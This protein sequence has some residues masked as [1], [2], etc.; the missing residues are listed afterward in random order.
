MGVAS[1][2]FD[3]MKRLYSNPLI[4][5]LPIICLF[6]YCHNSIKKEESKKLPKN[7]IGIPRVISNYRIT[8]LTDDT[9]ISR[10]MHIQDSLNTVFLDSIFN[11]LINQFFQELLKEPTSEQI[12]ELFQERVNDINF[13]NKNGSWERANEW[14]DM[15][16]STMQHSG[17]NGLSLFKKYE[18][19]LARLKN[20]ILIK[21]KK[22][23]D[24]PELDEIDPKERD[25]NFANETIINSTNFPLIVY[26]SG[27]TSKVLT[28][29]PLDTIRIDLIPGNYNLVARINVPGINENHAS[30]QYRGIHYVCTYFLN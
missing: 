1:Y 30:R 7:T 11:E 10:E 3:N 20:E 13:E 27:P 29:S 9:D 17:K 14:Y 22:A 18:S 12:E 25:G 19:G 28:I 5:A 2:F 21:N 24:I 8:L 23:K 26:Y 15:T 6:S 16:T 4:Y